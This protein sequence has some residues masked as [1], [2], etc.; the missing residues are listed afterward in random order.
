[1]NVVKIVL[2]SC[3]SVMIEGSL[4][5]QPPLKVLFIGNF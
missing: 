5:A 3:L 2:V 4:S 1:M